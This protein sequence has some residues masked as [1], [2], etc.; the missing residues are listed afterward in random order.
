MVD[1]LPL[2]ADSSEPRF[3]ISLDGAIVH[4]NRAAEDVL[5]VPAG[6]VAGRPCH[7][8]VRGR[9]ESGETV[10]QPD[11]P[12][13][14]EA[15]GGYSPSSHDLYVERGASAL[16]S[17]LRVHHLT[18]KDRAGAPL[19]LLHLI[20]DIQGS[21][22]QGTIG[23]DDRALAA[24]PRRRSSPASETA[25]FLLADGGTQAAPPA[26]A[27][28]RDWTRSLHVLREQ[29]PTLVAADRGA[30]LLELL[31]AFPPELVGSEPWLLH[32]RGIALRLASDA[33]WDDAWQVQTRARDLFSE[34]GDPE[35]HAYAVAELGALAT[36]L[37]RP[38]QAELLLEEATAELTRSEAPQRAAALC[39]LA[40]TYL[41]LNRVMDAQQAGEEAL[42]L[43]ASWPPTEASANLQARAL[44][45]LAL[46]Q[47][48][49]GQPVQALELAS[50]VAALGRN[51]PLV[52]EA[53]ILAGY[54]QGLVCWSLGDIEGA[55]EL[56]TASAGLA[57]EHNLSCLRR[58]IDASRAEM[59]G[60]LDRLDEADALFRE[61][62]EPATYLGDVAM[63]RFL[64]GRFYE[65]HVVFRRELDEANP[66]GNLADAM[67]AT[68]ALGAVAI[69]MGR[70]DEAEQ[71][72]LE[73]IRMAEHT[74]ARARLAGMNLHLAYLYL[75]R[76][77]TQRSR[78]YLRSALDF[79]AE[80]E[81][82]FFFLWH[83]ETVARVAAQA[84]ADSIQPD[85]VEALCRRS[86]PA[87]FVFHFLPLQSHADPAVRSHAAGIINELIA[88]GGGESA[89]AGLARCPQEAI[90]LR[91][92]NALATKRL[93]AQGLLILR[94]QHG[95][96]WAELDVFVEHYL[97]G[98][99][100]PVGA[101][102]PER[103]AAAHRLG[104]SEN[105][106]MH[107]VTSIRRKVGIGPRR[108]SIGIYTWALR[109]G[110]AG[111]PTSG[112]SGADSG[113]SPSSPAT[114]AASGS[115]LRRESAPGWGWARTR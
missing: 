12:V 57:V 6:Q 76:G 102:E 10:C 39:W 63:L 58:A 91:L 43:A 23:N 80:G 35:G 92:T 9:T 69:H 21:H 90:R 109:T 47:V 19:G 2:L 25:T 101:A 3:A 7:A 73:A 52:S 83:P 99:L 96:T 31:E 61:V 106:L 74:G 105:T 100:A 26:T 24:S 13:L 45:V 88:R 46:A 22:E 65:A 5:Q 15:R 59:L 36:L 98:A 53:R 107:H 51:Q 77:E 93:T 113:N 37:R 97:S 110:I 112:R 17:R 54:V 28:D 56:L 114:I 11:C 66:A 71:R 1:V 14:S 89:V 86:L 104:V 64:Q 67:R 55:F 85:Y 111:I 78:R 75:L 82:F 94:H 38:L 42:A 34:R 33:R 81:Y 79:A 49:V 108:T 62:G 8:V 84:L 60:Y 95:L 103:R 30:D 70:L 48:R 41:A 68:A 20:E 18:L 40:D 50:R 115:P 16:R 87:R 44:F 27:P 32:Y 72:L 4:W 29:G